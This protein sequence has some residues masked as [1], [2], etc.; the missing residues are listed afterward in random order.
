MFWQKVVGLKVQVTQGTNVTKTTN[1]Y[2][3]KQSITTLA[4]HISTYKLLLINILYMFCCP[5]IGLQQDW[6]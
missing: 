3:E 5:N 1:K 6:E 2:D 4:Y